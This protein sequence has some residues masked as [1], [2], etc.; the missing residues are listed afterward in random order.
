MWA[1]VEDTIS[2]L[3]QNILQLETLKHL[4]QL[5]LIIIFIIKINFQDGYKF[6]TKQS[7]K[8][9]VEMK[10]VQD[11]KTSEWAFV[12]ESTMPHSRLPYQRFWV[13]IALQV[14][15]E[16][17]PL[18][19]SDGGIHSIRMLRINTCSVSNQPNSER[20][21]T[22]QSTLSLS[23]MQVRTLEDTYAHYRY[24]HALLKLQ[25]TGI[26]ALVTLEV[27]CLI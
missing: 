5:Q 12:N 22:H 7:C 2:Q 27:C 17:G 8:W 19:V 21:L 16:V 9:A 11:L 20:S 6:W 24:T 23:C 26:L 15:G 1:L 4:F 10:W 3:R 13:D 18:I 14:G 25:Y